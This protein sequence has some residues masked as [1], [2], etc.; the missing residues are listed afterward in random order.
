M[1]SAFRVLCGRTAAG[2]PRVADVAQDLG[3]TDG[4][5]YRWKQQARVD[6]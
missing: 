1:R 4:S 3:V 2:V 6:R 5:L